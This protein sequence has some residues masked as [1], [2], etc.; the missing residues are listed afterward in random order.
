MVVI[1]HTRLLFLCIFVFLWAGRALAGKTSAAKG[2]TTAECLACHNDSTLTKE[3]NGKQVSLYVSEEK[4]KASMHGNLFQCADCHQDVKAF[5]HEPAPA[6]VRCAACHAE[7]QKQYQASFHSKA[8]KAGDSKA[9]TCAD[10][11]GSPHELLA[12]ADPASK[13]NH[14]NIPATCGACHGQKYVMEGAGLTNQPFVSYEAS[15]HGRAVAAGNANAAVCTD[16]HGVHDITR[17]DDPAGAQAIKVHLL[18]VCRQCHQGAGPNFPSAWIGHY[19]P[20]PKHAVLM[21]AVK[22][23]YVI[24]I[25]FVIGGLLLQI[26]LQLWRV[27]VSR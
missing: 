21:Y 12:A 22:V 5:P 18:T 17:M 3:S 20:S 1:R 2:M 23:F 14:N 4:F 19:E 15:V 11:H 26:L 8:I 13:V 25:P 6:T 27:V 24:F 16:C 7:E 10:C 9:A